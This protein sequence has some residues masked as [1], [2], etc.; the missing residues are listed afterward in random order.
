MKKIF[1]LVI[2][3]LFANIGIS[4]NNC[5]ATPVC[6]TFTTTPSGTGSGG[7]FGEI[8]SSTDGCLNGEHNSTWI[9]IAILT[10]GTLQF[11]IDPIV[12]TND[13][14]FAVWGPSSP[15]PPTAGPVRCSFAAGGGN[16]GLNGTASD[17]SENVFGN[18]WLQEMNVTA[19]QTYLILVDNF[20]T[21]NGFQMSFGGTSTL[22]CTT[23]PIELISFTGNKE[24]NY[25]NLFWT[26]ASELN[27]DYFILERSVDAFEW[28]EIGRI[29]GAGNSTYTLNYNFKDYNFNFGVNYYRL[30]QVD[31]NGQREQFNII[32]IENEK[33]E[34]KI[35]KVT[36]IM[37]QEVKE[38]FT[39]VKIV[40]Y[41]DGSVVKKI[42]R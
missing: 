26:T 32:A 40:Y 36:K 1:F 42:G 2:L 19:G 39:G 3:L 8:T 21:N 10:S 16:T 41:S 13:F 25:N 20:T 15:C 22:N 27:N 6:G 28:V 12:N 7:Q 30:T 9:S 17:V 34:K 23:L 11:T 18:G 14:D 33:I 31:Y 37:G 38:D 5:P 4:Q 35:I 29:N 24:N